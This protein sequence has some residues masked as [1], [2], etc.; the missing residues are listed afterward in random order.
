MKGESV[1]SFVSVDMNKSTASSSP[2]VKAEKR[3]RKEC[4]EDMCYYVPESLDEFQSEGLVGFL[5]LL[6][7]LR[8]HLTQPAFILSSPFP[9][10]SQAQDRPDLKVSCLRCDEMSTVRSAMCD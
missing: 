3:E 7:A 8:L 4:T 6:K 1:D 9:R 2:S 5:L 10:C